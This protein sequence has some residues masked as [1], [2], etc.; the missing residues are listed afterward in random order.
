MGPFSALFRRFAGFG[1][2]SL[3]HGG[4]RVF[5]MPWDIMGDFGR[6]RE[7]AVSS[8]DWQRFRFIPSGLTWPVCNRFPLVSELKRKSKKF[9]VCSCD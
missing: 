5:G 1:L 6:Q 9:L 8:W 3:S 4:R 7:L 2:E